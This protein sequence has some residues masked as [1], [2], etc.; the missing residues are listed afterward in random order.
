MSKRLLI[1]GAGR[2]I[3]RATALQAGARGWSVCVNYVSDAAAAEQVAGDIGRAGGRAFTH[4]A[5]VAAESDVLGLFGA[6]AA[7]FG[8]LDA[9]VVNAGIVAPASVLADMGAERLRRIVDINVMGALLCARE[10]ARSLSRSRGGAGG[11]IVIVS[12]AASRLGSPAEYVDYAASKGATDSLTIGLSKELAPEGIRVNA[13]RPAF[14]ETE[15]H[16]ASGRPD[17]AKLLGAQTP[18]GRAGTAE[19][20]AEAILWLLDDASSYVT[21]TFIDMAGGR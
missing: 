11:S 4:R 20:V 15:I 5:D 7:A 14:I 21:G 6:A 18:Q 9:V 13:V 12:S 19:E 8:G 3:G 10:A 1:T 2:G 17:R 16:A